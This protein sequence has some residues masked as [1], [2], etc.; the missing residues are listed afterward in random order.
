MNN[1]QISMFG[2]FQIYYITKSPLHF[3]NSKGQELLAYLLIH[4]GQHHREIIANVIWENTNQTRAKN[5]L[6]KALWQLQSNL[7]ELEIGLSERTL[8]I[9]DEWISVNPDIYL[10]LDVAKFEEAFNRT[11][12]I[13]GNKITTTS[14]GAIEDAINLYQGNLLEGWYQNW[15][16][17]ER[18]RLQQMYFVMLEK[19][20]DFCEAHGEWERGQMYGSQILRYDSAHEPTHRRLMRLYYLS[21]DRTAAL[22]QYD[23]CKE[24]LQNELGVN[25]SRLTMKLYQQ[26]CR[27]PIT[28]PRPATLDGFIGKHTENSLPSMLL[29]LE[30]LNRTLLSIQ[31]QVNQQIKQIE[32]FLKKSE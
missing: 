12:D 2:Q 5:Y 22:R 17:I 27:D 13:P 4:R 1:L 11:Q 9:T 19:L 26:I 25:P 14:L 20:M 7:K 21:K 30:E 10:N 23:R 24:A 31:N 15:C 18:E 16:L 28:T 8:Q 3:R 29:Q 32:T 6:R